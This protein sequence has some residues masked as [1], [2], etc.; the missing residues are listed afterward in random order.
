VI[1][2]T[3]RHICESSRKVSELVWLLGRSG[4]SLNLS[5]FEPQFFDRPV[6]IF[7]IF[8]T[9]WNQSFAEEPLWGFVL[10][11]NAASGS[12]IADMH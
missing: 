4:K 7:K 3:P 1:F 12:R 2:C 6:Q 5:G 10:M 9:G 8:S 11:G